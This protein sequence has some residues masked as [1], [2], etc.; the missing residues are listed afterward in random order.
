MRPPGPLEPRPGPLPPHSG[1][2][3]HARP[4]LLPR[5]RRFCVLDPAPGVAAQLAE[6]GVRHVVY[7]LRGGLEVV[8]EAAAHARMLAE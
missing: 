5:P 1:H 7:L 4:P 3:T 6:R 8:R 2:P